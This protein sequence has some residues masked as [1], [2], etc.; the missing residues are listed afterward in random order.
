[1]RQSS[2]VSTSFH[3]HCFLRSTFFCNLSCLPPCTMLSA[4]YIRT[5]PAAV[6]HVW[7]ALHERGH[8]L[9]C[10]S[11]KHKHWS[12]S[13]VGL[14][15]LIDRNVQTCITNNAL[16]RNDDTVYCSSKQM[17]IVELGIGPICSSVPS[18]VSRDTQNETQNLSGGA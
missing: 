14:H 3:T 15:L 8:H 17:E 5:C 1:M 6:E 12:H 13:R 9:I 2:T 7:V 16:F 18:L 4:N 11:T 10:Q